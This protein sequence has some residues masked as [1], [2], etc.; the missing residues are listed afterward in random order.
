MSNEDLVWKRSSPIRPAGGVEPRA[1]IEP[2][3]GGF[4]HAPTQRYHYAHLG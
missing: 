1:G 3:T 4:L 2:A